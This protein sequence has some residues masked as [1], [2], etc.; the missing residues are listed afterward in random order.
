MNIAFLGAGYVG[1][2]S[3]AVFAD[4]G[5]KVWAVDVVE[6][7]VRDLKEGKVSFFEPGLSELVLKGVR[8]GRLI[9]TTDYAKAVP[10][11]EVIFIAV[12]TP[13]GKGGGADLSQVFSAA[14]ALAPFLSS[15]Y[16]VVVNK[17]TV[18]PGT[19]QRVTEVIKEGNSG[20]NFEVASCPEFLRE[21][22]AVSDTRQPD[23][24]VLG[25]DTEKAFRI[26]EKLHQP[27]G[28]PIV[29]TSVTSAE[30]IKYAANAYLAL[31]IGFIDQMA[32]LC[33]AV[34]GTVRYG[35]GGA[36]IKDIIKGIGLDK[37]IGD[38]YWYPGIGYGG[39]C[40]PKDVMALGTLFG[41]YV[42][43]DNLFSKLDQYNRARPS[44]YIG[45]VE[46]ILGDL[47]GKVIGILGLTAKPQSGDMRGSQAIPFI[48][49]LQE[50]G[51]RVRAF[52]PAGLE[53]A[54]EMLEG[55]EFCSEPYGVVEGADALCILCERED[56]ESF[57]WTRVKK[58]MRGNLVFDAKR[59]FDPEKLSELGF[60]YLGVGV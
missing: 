23:R 16:T 40:F 56:F 52:D 9:P 10:N 44:R 47:S 33:E 50:K 37:R 53:E 51:A 7:K 24:V 6:S 3:G 41:E 55:V 15:D 27:L 32:N 14:K 60:R 43:K 46:I 2:T 57:S 25:T 28:A 4:L 22:S 20:A 48:R 12:G 8:S 19:A 35:A 58:L 11:S 13:T 1:L 17:S 18:P 34:P 59:M 39:Y 36:D 30:I 49:I 31:R 5:N 38:H 42:S 21:G 26:L 45:K 54:K 29:R